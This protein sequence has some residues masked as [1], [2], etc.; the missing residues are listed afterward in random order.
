MSAKKEYISCRRESPATGI[1][2]ELAGG[3]PRMIE[4]ES[5]YPNSALSLF[6]QHSGW[7]QPHQQS[8]LGRM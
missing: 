2:L 8:R 6:D 1:T 5:S 3:F 7:Y 4:E